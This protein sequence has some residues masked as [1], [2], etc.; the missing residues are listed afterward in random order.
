MFDAS[1]PGEMTTP[2]AACKALDFLR[3]YGLVGRFRVSRDGSEFRVPVDGRVYV[4]GAQAALD[5]FAGAIADLVDAVSSGSCEGAE[6]T[7]DLAG[8][9]MDHPV[10]YVEVFDDR[11]RLFRERWKDPVTDVMIEDGDVRVEG[12]AVFP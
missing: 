2:H 7:T 10:P 9:R 6:F 3:L 8:V 12:V 11:V 1:A 5:L 4:M